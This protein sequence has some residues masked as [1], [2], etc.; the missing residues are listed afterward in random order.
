MRAAVR[1][2]VERL[3]WWA[4]G[5]ALVAAPAFA[6]PSTARPR[7]SANGL[8][9]IRFTQLAPQQCVLEV[10][11]QDGPSWTLPRC[12]GAVEDL[13]FVSNDGQAFWVLHPVPRV[14]DGKR[15]KQRPER[16]G[17]VVVAVRY[18]RSGKM[19]ES[20]SL[21]SFVKG[22]DREKLVDLG[23]RF[24]WLAGTSGAPGVAPRMT[25]AGVVELDTVADKRYRL[26]F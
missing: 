12:V 22:P 1:T 24:G 18:D 14:P 25:D 8:Y 6:S 19:L 26:K 20:R 23:L 13:F 7:V 2:G 10:S 17:Q 11:R 9:T 3:R 5:A 15:N 21:G 4:L 16:W